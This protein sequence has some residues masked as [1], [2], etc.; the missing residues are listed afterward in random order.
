[1]ARDS[2]IIYY[3]NLTIAENAEKNHVS[4]SGMNY[5]I[6]TH[7]IDR[8]YENSARLISECRKY[9]RKHPKAT[10]GE[11]AKETGYSRFAV[12][13]HWEYISTDATYSKLNPKK[14][15]I[16][17]EENAE[18]VKTHT[19]RKELLSEALTDIP[20]MFRKADEADVSEFRKFIMEEPQKPMLFIGSG[21]MG[22]SFPALLYGMGKG[23]GQAITPYSFASVSDDAVKNS[24]CMLMS[25]GGNND[26]IAYAA[27]R[28]VKL[29]P[30]NTACYT[31]ETGK[32]DDGRNYLL[33]LLN[34]TGA[35][36]F[37]YPHPYYLTR[38][39]K[40]FL[41]SRT[42]FY[43]YA[44]LYRAFTGKTI[45]DRIEVDLAPEKC[46]TYRLNKEGTNL[47]N[48]RK[49]NHFCV[50]YGGFGQPVAGDIE[51]MFAETGM[52]SVQMSDYRNFCHGRFIFVGNHTKNPKEPR[53][54]SD[55][56]VIML[57]T[58]RE[59]EIAKR[60]LDNVIPYQTPIVFIE[61]ALNSPLATIDLM[62]KSNVFISYVGEKCYGINP[63]SPENYSSIDKEFPIQGVKFLEELNRGGNLT[64]DEPDNSVIDGWKRQIDDYIAQEHTNTEQIE[65]EKSYLPYPTKKDLFKK[66]K[67]QYDASKY[68]CY[69]FRR[70][71]DLHKTEQMPLGNMNGGFPF[72]INGIKFHTSESAYICGLFSDNTEKHQMIQKLLAEE[73]NGY[74]A[75]KEIRGAYKGEG[76][77]DW[78]SF[79]IEWMLYVVWQKVQGNKE[80]RDILMEIPEGATIIENST[81]HKKSVPDTAAF[82]GCRNQ[83][84]KDFHTIVGK[85]VSALNPTSDAEKDRMVSAYMNDFCNHGI[86]EG[87]NE[88]GKILM[89]VKKCLHDGT[90]PQIDY[91]LLKSKNIY[92]MG[93]S[94]FSEEQPKL[95][96]KSTDVEAIEPVSEIKE[97]K[98]LE[99]GKGRKPYYGMVRCSDKFAYFF[100]G[101]PFSNWW[102]SPEMKYDGCTFR[103]SEAIYMYL[104]AKD[105][106]DTDVMRAIVEADNDLAMEESKRFA[107]VKSLGKQAGKKN[108]KAPNFS[109]SDDWMYEALKVKFQ[110]DSIFKDA[111][112]SDEYTGKTFVEAS[113]YDEIWGIKA[114]ATDDVVNGGVS[115][116]KGTNL[117]GKVLTKFRDSLKTKTIRKG[118][119][120]AVIGDIAG[121]SREGSSKDVYTT[122]FDLF[123]PRSKPTDDSVLTIAVADWLMNQ[124]TM[125]IDESLR[126]W[127]KEYPR[128][129]YGG[130]FKKFISDGVRYCSNRN[131]AA[132]RVSPVAIVSNSL[133]ETLNLAD[134]VS[135]PTHNSEEGLKGAKSIAASVYIA[136]E[137][138]KKNVPVDEIKKSIRTYVESNF[139]Y[140]LDE[141]IE[142]IRERSKRLAKAKVDFRRT[143]IPSADFRHM[144]EASLSCPMAIIAF[145]LGD[146]YESVIRLAISMGGDS[147]TIAAMAGSIAAQAY[148]IPEDIIAKAYEIMPQKMIDVVDRFSE[149][150]PN[151]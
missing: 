22:G 127:G 124:D 132:M 13:K 126:K 33:S 48:L 52:A 30:R 15:K 75:K 98:Y 142:D 131:G 83:S 140:N 95:N 49:I 122:D 39:K 81:F 40:G 4:I 26:D 60:L 89:I 36:V 2:K 101:V 7:N 73:T 29:N 70:K 105:C 47:P 66:E 115:L 106:G 18:S 16:H 84:M 61:S 103:S 151:M 80:F 133:E 56:A 97:I 1:M 119:M 135:V 91:E 19:N 25:A 42:K 150:Y 111:L 58:P 117:L 148:G 118:I 41:S 141:S 96:E 20:E 44:I 62:V 121:S 93:Q 6:K 107:K 74:A 77:K 79:N 23:I 78:K 12:N 76:R 38:Q 129:G 123:P 54:E 35:R 68:L 65:S 128:A 137:G 9:F 10:K 8:R 50:L 112:L 57:I 32:D 3:E 99:R 46:F 136:K 82:W 71:G 69:A 143:G 116:W 67:E 55:A 147:D 45:S 64:Y 138:V 24:R 125:S 14:V 114:A 51:S 130:G 85:Y 43:K 109:K 37:K 28:C 134:S 104:K 21:G 90:E 53:I 144:S 113:P 120:G 110:Y 146:S 92:L 86:F 139:G 94:V 72:K 11:I 59:K 149:K 31:Y 27:R 145:L 108:G 63:N 17:A 88:M 100:M 34:G 102:L 87:N 5:Y